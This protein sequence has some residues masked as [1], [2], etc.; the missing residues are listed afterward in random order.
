MGVKTKY[1][2]DPEYF[3]RIHAAWKYKG[4]HYFAIDGSEADL[5]KRPFGTRVS[6]NPNNKTIDIDV[7]PKMVPVNKL[8]Y[9]GEEES[10]GGPSYYSQAYAIYESRWVANTRPMQNIYGA[11]YKDWLPGQMYSFADGTTATSARFKLHSMRIGDRVIRDIPTSI[12]NSV[13]APMLLGQS[14]LQRLGKYTMDYK[15][16][17]ITFD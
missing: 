1:E 6:Y 17:T 11:V 4:L 2:T 9:K 8:F 3:S 10:F 12:A 15:S 7:Q 14:A 13:R 5:V 16:G